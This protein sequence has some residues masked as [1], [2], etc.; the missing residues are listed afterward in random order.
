MAEK[1]GIT[2]RWEPEV[3]ARIDKMQKSS[4]IARSFGSIANELCLQGLDYLDASAFDPTIRARVESVL[5]EHAE[6]KSYTKKSE[7][8][9]SHAMP[10]TEHKKLRAG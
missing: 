3:K 7:R 10:E 1:S 4:R 6:E 9:A 2:V 8:E 5:A